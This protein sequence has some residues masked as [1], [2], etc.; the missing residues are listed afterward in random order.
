[1]FCCFQYISF[2]NVIF[3]IKMNG[4][5]RKY[6]DLNVLK[7]NNKQNTNFIYVKLPEWR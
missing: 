1:M 2:S 6:F 4:S 5:L 7:K 3:A